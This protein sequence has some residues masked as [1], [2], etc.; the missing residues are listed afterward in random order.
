MST[1]FPPLFLKLR[2]SIAFKSLCIR[3]AL[4]SR[5]FVSSHRLLLKSTSEDLRAAFLYAARRSNVGSPYLPFIATRKAAEIHSKIVLRLALQ[6]P[7]TPL[8]VSEMSLIDMLRAMIDDVHVDRSIRG[9]HPDDLIVAKSDLSELL[10]LFDRVA[11]YPPN[12][13]F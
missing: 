6:L 4:I 13:A 8:T 5:A 3:T 2:F 9:L 7:H 11:K 12:E 10:E 1:L